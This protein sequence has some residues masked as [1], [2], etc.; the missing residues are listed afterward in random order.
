MIKS[1]LRLKRL[2]IV[3]INFTRPEKYTILI[4]FKKSKTT[5]GHVC[6]SEHHFIMFQRFPIVINIGY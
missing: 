4:M 2:R 6:Y 3:F 5:C 1:L